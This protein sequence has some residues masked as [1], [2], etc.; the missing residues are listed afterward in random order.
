MKPILHWGWIQ[1]SG[2][3]PA[4]PVSGKHVLG[5]TG[6][7]AG[8]KIPDDSWHNCSPLHGF[9]VTSGRTQVHADAHWTL[10]ACRLTKMTTKW[11]WVRLKVLRLSDWK[12]FGL[13]V[14]RN[15]SSTLPL[16]VCALKDSCLIHH[17]HLAFRSLFPVLVS[18]WNFV[19]PSTRWQKQDS[20]QPMLEGRAN[21]SLEVLTW[22][23]NMVI[24]DLCEVT[25][26]KVSARL[27]LLE[28][29]NREETLITVGKQSSSE[30][31]IRRDRR[32]AKQRLPLHTNTEKLRDLR[33]TEI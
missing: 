28:F 16:H 21:T 4:F 2:T 13:L 33:S 15:S 8:A 26:R 25:Q 23:L 20:V 22:N 14:S 7:E 6:H 24:R 29:T 3:L 9:H 10:C 5:L 27:C 32:R 19:G 17:S 18:C 31:G 12:T 30:Y 11:R 1:A